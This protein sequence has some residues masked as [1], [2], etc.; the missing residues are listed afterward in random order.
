MVF[1]AKLSAPILV[2]F[3]Y[4]FRY[5]IIILK[6]PLYPHLGI[7]ILIWASKR[8]SLRVFVVR[9]QEDTIVRVSEELYY[10]TFYYDD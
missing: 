6:K 4:F 10:L 1:S 7:L 8:F 2:H 5:S 3:I 9:V